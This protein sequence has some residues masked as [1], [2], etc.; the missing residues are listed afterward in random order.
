MKWL[1][2]A[3]LVCAPLAGFSQSAG[4]VLLKQGLAHL[5][6]EHLD[7]AQFYIEA[8]VTQFRINLSDT[9]TIT[10]AR[11]ANS[12]Q[13]L[14]SI[15][16]EQKQPEKALAMQLEALRIR[17]T[18]NLTRQMMDSYGSVAA[19]LITQ[20]RSEEAIRYLDRGIELAHTSG[21][22]ENLPALIKFSALAQFEMKQYGKAEEKLLE[23][24]AEAE[25]QEAWHYAADICG[26]LEDVTTDN[27]ELSRKERKKKLEVYAAQKAA[28][29]AKFK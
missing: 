1:L 18:Y 22:L 28:F 5:N 26:F 12:L 16:Q 11:I 8:A 24:L 6:K 3:C 15:Y 27:P 2:W 20:G 21:N 19:L 9:D 4:E 25:R 23:A 7:S 14:G 10:H 17:R 29:E 13:Y